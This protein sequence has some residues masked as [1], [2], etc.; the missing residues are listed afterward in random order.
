MAQTD[1]DNHRRWTSFSS[2]WLGLECSKKKKNCKNFFFF[3]L[4]KLLDLQLF[5]NFLNVFAHF[6]IIVNVTRVVLNNRRMLNTED[7]HSFNVWDFIYVFYA[8][9][10]TWVHSGLHVITWVCMMCVCLGIQLNSFCSVVVVH[11]EVS[12]TLW[13]PAL[14][15]CMTAACISWAWKVELSGLARLRKLKRLGNV[16]VC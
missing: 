4:L 3:Y 12:Q 11:R 1:P 13:L 14:T 2:R 8:S 10:N 6:L 16:S 7:F 9:W 15:V 5:C